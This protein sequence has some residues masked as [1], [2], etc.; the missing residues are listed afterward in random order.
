MTIWLV[1]CQQHYSE[2]TPRYGHGDYPDYIDYILG[3]VEANTLRS[4][5]ARAR[6]IFPGLRCGGRF[7]AMVIATS[8][9]H[10]KYYRKPA[11]NRLG[12][13]AT[14]VHNH[15]LTQLIKASES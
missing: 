7:G 10:A 9:P 15:A 8:D 12:P 14:A 4:A 11:D 13:K 6:K 1:I 5:Q 3:I 2:N